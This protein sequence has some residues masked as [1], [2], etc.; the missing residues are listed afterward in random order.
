MF[1]L[2]PPPTME[3][4]SL[5]MMK[6]NAIEQPGARGIGKLSQQF[7]FI[8]LLNKPQLTDIGTKKAVRA[9]A[10]R[11]FRRRRGEPHHSR[12]V[13]DNSGIKAA[14]S[15]NPSPNVQPDLDGLVLDRPIWMLSMDPDD[16]SP[17]LFHTSYYMGDFQPFMPRERKEN[18]V[19]PKYYDFSERVAYG[20][21]LAN[22][23]DENA[24]ASLPQRPRKRKKLE[25]HEASPATLNDDGNVSQKPLGCQVENEMILASPRMTKLLGAGLYDPFNALPIASNRRIHILV[26]HCKLI[27]P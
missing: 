21:N 14:G 13:L 25:D 20:N 19:D 3:A 5:R 18:V 23:G 27:Q 7:E 11:D 26:H 17:S 15:P 8:N 1:K 9:H 24:V 10:M 4:S 2:I 22:F 6:Q 16:D 12:R